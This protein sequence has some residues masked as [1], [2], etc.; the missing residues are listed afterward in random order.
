[1]FFEKIIKIKTTL[2]LEETLYFNAMN[3]WQHARTQA[4][5]FVFF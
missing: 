1:L 2:I 5:M 3:I 4:A